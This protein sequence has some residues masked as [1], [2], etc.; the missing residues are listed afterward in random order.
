MKPVQCCP[1]CSRESSASGISRHR[2]TCSKYRL[3]T[4][5]RQEFGRRVADAKKLR[6][7]QNLRAQQLGLQV[8]QEQPENIV[9]GPL[10]DDTVSMAFIF[11]LQKPLTWHRHIPHCR[12]GHQAQPCH[13][14]S[15]GVHNESGACQLVTRTCALSL[16]PRPSHPILQRSNL[17]WL[18]LHPLP[19]PLHLLQ[20]PLYSRACPLSCGTGSGPPQMASGSGRSTYTDPHMILTPSFLPK[21]YTVLTRPQSAPTMTC[22]RNLLATAANPPNFS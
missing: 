22:K 9:S 3:F 8:G 6:R 2:Q 7:A 12:C 16:L 4:A 15:L 20:R 14:H 5:D 21:I 11:C 17:L 19:Q 13:Y 1:K 10:A 18:P